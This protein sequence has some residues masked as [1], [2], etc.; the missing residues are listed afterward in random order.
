[1]TKKENLKNNLIKS[2]FKE[3]VYSILY[4]GTVNNVSDWKK[5]MHSHNFSEIIFVKKGRGQIIINDKKYEVKYGDIVVY[6][7][8][9]MHQELYYINEEFKV[10]FLAVKV[11]SDNRQERL[12]DTDSHVVS[13]GFNALKFENYFGDVVLEM[14]KKRTNST[15]LPIYLAG[16][17]VSIVKNMFNKKEEYNNDLS[18]ICESV[19][20]VIDRDFCIIKKSDEVL[21][22]L[23]ISKYYFY[24][25]F[26]EMYN[27]SPLQYLKNKKIK[28]AE[29]LL[30]NTN[31]KI[32]GIASIL[33][34]ENELYFS[35]IFKKE[36]GLSATEY[37][38]NVKKS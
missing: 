6:N 16:I 9:D 33:G 32:A 34:Y 10:Y 13:A 21:K 8:Q 4:S 28:Y 12:V 1:M 5:N 31:L 36:K 27:V 38:E 22:D 37:R 29:E 7:P 26:K 17:I 25:K 15:D 19:K 3:P 35:R 18:D 24:D 23:Y 11:L 2:I 14:Q 30:K 20:R